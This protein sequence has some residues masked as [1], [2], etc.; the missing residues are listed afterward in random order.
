MNSANAT[1]SREDAIDPNKTAKFLANLQ[2]TVGRREPEAAVVQPSSEAEPA[3]SAA[4]AAPIASVVRSTS[5]G[6][7]APALAE[8]ARAAPKS[9]RKVKANDRMSVD[10]TLD[11]GTASRVV[12]VRVDKTLADRLALIAFQNKINGNEGPST[13]NDIGIAALNKWLDE[14][15]AAA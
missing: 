6:S 1:P 2:R 4:H 12:Y 14:Y 7:N 13:I 8:S 11:P 5:G 3:E 15:E 9:V 10:I